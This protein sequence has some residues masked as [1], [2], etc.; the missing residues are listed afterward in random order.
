[1]IE[2]VAEKF[3]LVSAWVGA[4]VT[5]FIFGFLFVLGLPLFAGGRFLDI[6]TKSW[7]PHLGMFGIYPMIAG[8]L[9]ISLL[10]MLVAFPLCMGCSILISVVA[11]RRVSRL[12]RRTVEA[13]TGVPTVIYG[14]VGIFLLVPFVR[15]IFAGGS[16]MCVLSA[17]LMLAL[18]VSPT[19]ILLFSDAFERVPRSYGEAVLASGGTR[20]SIFSMSRCPVPGRALPRDSS[21]PWAGPWGIR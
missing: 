1:M 21:S 8:T 19:M 6:V 3:F 13:M 7:A 15:R 9:A 14:F 4:L 10:A 5:L 12:L 16:G 18:V 20:S 17:S 2:W 11:P